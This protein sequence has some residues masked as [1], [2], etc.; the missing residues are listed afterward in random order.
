M[1]REGNNPLRRRLKTIVVGK[2]RSPYDRSLMHKLSLVAFFAWVGLGADGLSSSCYGPEEAFLALGDHAYLAVFIALASAITIFVISASYSQI[3]ELFPR[4]GGGYLV[5]SRLLSPGIG[6]VSGCALLVDYVL[7]ITISIASCT[8]AIFSLLPLELYPYKIILAYAGILL[9]TILNMRGVRESVLPL[10]PIF[11]T[12]IVTHAFV[13]LYAVLTHTMQF[14]VVADDI[15]NDFRSAHV[16]IGLFGI[17][18]LLMRAYSMG[19]GTYTGIEAVSNSMPI[20][21]EPRVKTAKRTM[22][23]IAISLSFTVTGLVL[24][25]LLFRVQPQAGRTLNAVLFQKVV[26]GWGGW[27]E[28]F[29]LTTLFSEATLLFVAAQAGFFGGPRVLANMSIDQW[30][31]TR[32]SHL[33]DRFVTQNGVLMMSVGALAMMWLA[34]GS[35]KFLVILYSINVF[36]TF[37]LS[38]LGMVHYWWSNRSKFPYWL[39]RISVSAVGLVLTST[40]L[41]S[42]TIIKFYEGGW[43][44][45]FV[46][47]CLAVFVV[48]VKRH[49]R[50]TAGILR[51][52]DE[53]VTTTKLE[54]KRNSRAGRAPERESDYHAKTAAIFVNGFS[55]LG[56]HALYGVIRLFGPDF[57]NFIFIQVGTIDASVFHSAEDLRRL[58]DRVKKDIRQYVDLMSMKGYYAE[59]RTAIGTDVVEQ[60]MQIVPGIL[61]QFKNVVFFGGQLV[62]PRES[63]FTRLLHNQTV[64]AIQRRLYSEGIPFMLV[65]VRL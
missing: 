29:V 39:R 9:L 30:M 40:I 1:D 18:F 36:I 55:G 41:V 51:R 45:L 24:A 60:A 34:G 32:L 57:K 42:V 26:A 3:V 5:A 14:P 59:A 15:A 38:Q 11:I 33:S 25:Y 48:L 28:T 16:E 10:V 21:R 4:G 49:Y 56:L 64:F 61:E 37:T 7:T 19:A 44:S 52:L 47:G 43:I 23:Y 17:L 6:M 58:E 63:F 62:F 54:M 31:P 50:N 8:D 22:L 2:A 20:L 46:T 53:L 35:V 65:P 13:I 27:G 12:F